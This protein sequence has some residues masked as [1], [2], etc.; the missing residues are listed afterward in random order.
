MAVNRPAIVERIMGGLAVPAAQFLPTGMAGTLEKPPVEPF[1]PAGAKALLVEAG[2]P[3]GFGVTLSTPND[4][5]VNDVEIAQAVAQFWTRIGVRTEVEAMTAP[6][7]FTRRARRE[8][9]IAL[10]GWTS[11]TGEASS[12]L[13]QWATSA[14]KAAG[15]GGSNYGGYSSPALDGPLRKA[16]VT[17][18][19][20]AR[21]GLLRDAALVLLK[22][23]AYLP[24]HFENTIWAFR[25][26]LAY[27]GR[28]DQ[29]TLAFEVRSAR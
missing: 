17:V 24:L 15:L 22:D 16:L 26:G 14:D 11:S 25:N 19:D 9:S 18:D 7:F 20:G 4:R 5:Y 28:A 8:F 6:V 12:F 27:E 1:D 21:E 13:R 10:G 29:L 23:A 2:Y 3:D